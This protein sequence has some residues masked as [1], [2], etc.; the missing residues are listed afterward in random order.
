MFQ[1]GTLREFESIVRRF[2]TASSATVTKPF[3]IRLNICVATSISFAK[4]NASTASHSTVEGALDLNNGSI[5]TSS[6]EC[7]LNA[8]FVANT[9]IVLYNTCS[10]LNHFTLILYLPV[11]ITF[12]KTKPQGVK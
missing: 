12:M 9:C 10:K 3:K 1:T 5:W 7:L 2:D 4:I 8:D 11:L 6:V